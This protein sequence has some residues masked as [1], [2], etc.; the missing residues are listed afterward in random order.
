MNRRKFIKMLMAPALVAG[1]G[2][3]VWAIMGRNNPYYSG[4]VSDHFDGTRFFNPDR[5]RK[6][7]FADLLRWRFTAKPARWPERFPGA[8]DR[9]PSRVDDGS[10]RLSFI[11]HATVLVQTHGLNI[12]TDPHYSDRASPLSFAGPRRVNDPGVAFEDLPPIDAVLLSHNHYDHLDVATL[13]RLWKRDAPR[14]VT[15]LGNDAIVSAHDPSVRVEAYDWQDQIELG[16]GVTVHL[17]PAHHWSARGMRD[18]MMAL[19]CAFV[20]ETAG[21]NVYFA[22]DT[23]YGDGAHFRDTR[24]RFGD[25]RLAIL[26]IG[27][28]EPRWFMHD[29]HMNPAEAVKAK[30]DLGAELALAVHWGTFQLTDE[31]IEEPVRALEAAL[32]GTAEA[33]DTF[34]TLLPG[35]AW[36]VA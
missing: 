28:Y 29:S 11:G 15:A 35:Q 12:L 21:G 24:S 30:A 18:R 20:I 31:G 34:R 25:F 4:P 2:A 26:P 23:G 36:Q 27:A 9:P 1:G 33:E 3:A 5:P 14:I 6:M 32:A 13:S 19:W 16:K 10:T 8:V 7:G 22:G 17:Q